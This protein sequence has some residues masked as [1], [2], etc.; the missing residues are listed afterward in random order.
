M[1]VNNLLLIIPHQLHQLLMECD[2]IGTWGI[3][4]D[5]FTRATEDDLPQGWNTYHSK[6]KLSKIFMTIYYVIFRCR[7]YVRRNRQ[8][9]YSR[10]VSADPVL[11]LG[12]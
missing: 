8:H 11:R 4:Y 6:S 12:Q 10:W 9:S 5:I 7:G 3:S 2:E 1:D